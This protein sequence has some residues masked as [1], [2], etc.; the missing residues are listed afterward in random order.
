VA[1]ALLRGL[2]RGLARGLARE[3]AELAYL[4]GVSVRSHLGDVGALDVVDDGGDE[5]A[6]H[7]LVQGERR[8]S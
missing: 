3:L 7:V 5:G 2:V 1:A 4:E 6:V 8:P